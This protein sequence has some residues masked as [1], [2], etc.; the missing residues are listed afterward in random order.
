M[1]CCHC[2]KYFDEHKL[3]MMQPSLFIVDEF[4]ELVEVDENAQINYVCPQCGHLV[5]KDVDQ[6]ELKSLAQAS[7]SQLQRGAN[8]FARG[9]ALNLVGLIIGI[10]A[11]SFLLLSFQ[12]E[13]GVKVL[14]AG[15]STFLIFV[16]MAVIAVILLGFGIYFT[17]VGISKKRQ[18]SKLLKDLNNKTFVQQ[19]KV[20]NHL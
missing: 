7:H 12:N 16:V 18:Y 3:E 15:K 10:L 5:H 17:V 4:G 2:G 20:K 8:S 13:R 11:L 19:G 9:M 6:A 1:Y 14:N